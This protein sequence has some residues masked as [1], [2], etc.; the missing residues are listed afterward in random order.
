VF[1]LIGFTIFVLILSRFKFSKVSN[2]CSTVLIGAYILHLFCDAVAGG[3]AFLY[4]VKPVVT[5]DYYVS[6]LWW[7]PLDVVCSLTAY[8]IWRYPHLRLGTRKQR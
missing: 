2:R 7:I 4:P 1:G 6:A 5:G 8:F 3:V